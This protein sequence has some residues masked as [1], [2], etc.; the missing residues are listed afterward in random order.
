[1]RLLR[2]WNVRGL[3]RFSNALCLDFAGAFPSGRISRPT[4]S[5]R[6]VRKRHFFSFTVARW[7]CSTV[8]THLKNSSKLGIVLPCNITSSIMTF[9][10]APV[11]PFSFA[12]ATHC[13]C[14]TSIMHANT[15]AALRAPIGIAAK[16]SFSSTPKNASFGLDPL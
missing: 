15:G 8:R 2:S 11:T 13:S 16:V 14:N 4:N 6:L 1:M 12:R 10:S 9:E 5:S 3:P 7:R